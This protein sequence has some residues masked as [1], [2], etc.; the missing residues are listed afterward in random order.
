[1]ITC[2]WSKGIIESL[3]AQV[4]GAAGYT[5]IEVSI[6]SVLFVALLQ[7]F[8]LRFADG[9]KMR[10]EGL[11]HCLRG[12]IMKWYFDKPTSNAC[13]LWSSSISKILLFWYLTSK[14][15]RCV[16]LSCSTLAWCLSNCFF[17]IFSD[18]GGLRL[19]RMVSSSSLGWLLCTRPPTNLQDWSPFH[20]GS[21]YL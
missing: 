13:Y 2:E 9:L 8:D 10:V 1:M 4:A 6:N 12:P 3:A 19:M 21:D 7:C 15:L 20:R 14:V 16:L 17:P 18:Y 5:F 11:S